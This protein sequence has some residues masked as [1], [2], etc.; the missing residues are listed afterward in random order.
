M[1]ASDLQRLCMSLC[2]GG[3]CVWILL[4]RN[5]IGPYAL[6]IQLEWNGNSVLGD[7]FCPGQWAL[8][9]KQMLKYATTFYCKK[10]KEIVIIQFK[11]QSVLRSV[12]LIQ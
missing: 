7:F 8:S 9:F 5:F 1:A 10:K 6:L 3:L 12:E 11:N 2:L 4:D